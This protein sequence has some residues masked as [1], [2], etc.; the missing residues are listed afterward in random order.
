[1]RL[2]D[3]AAGEIIGGH[4]RRQQPEIGDAPIAV[5][6]TGGRQQPGHA[7]FVRAAALQRHEA[8]ERDGQEDQQELPGGEKHSGLL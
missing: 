7:Q 3:E 1:M 2:I 6:H 8:A 5:E 4:G